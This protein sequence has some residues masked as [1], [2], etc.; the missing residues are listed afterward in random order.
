[1]NPIGPFCAIYSTK[2]F[3]NVVKLI[4]PLQRCSTAELGCR[5][6]RLGYAPFCACASTCPTVAIL[7]VIVLL[8]WKKTARHLSAIFSATSNSGDDCFSPVRSP[9]AGASRS[10]VFPAPNRNTE[11]WIDGIWCA[12]SHGCIAVKQAG[13][14]SVRRLVGVWAALQQPHGRPLSIWSIKYADFR[15]VW[16]IIAFVKTALTF[17][18][19]VFAFSFTFYRRTIKERLIF[20]QL[21]EL[22]LS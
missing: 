7:V 2:L 11:P 4:A 6:A 12:I 5:Q 17:W 1:M 19:Y 22:S 18:L 14:L 3:N 15:I 10:Y 13:C 9:I 8:W 16:L 21:S 20:R